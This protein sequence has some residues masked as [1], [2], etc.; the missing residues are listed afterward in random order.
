MTRTS[1]PI[2]AVKVP[3]WMVQAKSAQGELDADTKTRN[4]LLRSLL[5]QDKRGF[6]LVSQRWRALRR[7]M[8]SPTAI[9]DIAKLVRA[10]VQFEHKG[11]QLKVAE[12]TSRPILPLQRP[13]ACGRLD[14]W[15]VIYDSMP[16]RVQAPMAAHRRS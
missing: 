11:D 6:A 9:G 2:P 1:S 10:L 15:L 13:R 7:A 4:A 3:D 12:K 8:V 14:H 5:Y 16:R